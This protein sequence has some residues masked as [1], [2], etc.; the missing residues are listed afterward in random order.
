MDWRNAAHLLV[1]DP[2]EFARRVP[3]ALDWRWHRSW[4]PI[5]QSETRRAL[6]GRRVWTT[7]SLHARRAPL[8]LRF[9]NAQGSPVSEL[10]WFAEELD[11]VSAGDLQVRFVDS[12]TTAD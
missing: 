9:A 6:D 11:R 10:T 2:R 3:P 7:R 12:W 1:T 8:V 4:D 5:G